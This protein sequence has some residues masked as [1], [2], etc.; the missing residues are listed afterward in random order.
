MIAPVARICDMHVCAMQTPA[1]VPI[2]HVGGTI[3]TPGVPTVLAGGIPIVALG[4]C[5][6]CVVGAIP[7]PFIVGSFTVLAMGRPIV[8][9]SDPLAHGGN[10]IIGFPTV[11]VGDSGGGGS[12]Q[13]ATMSAAKAGGSAFTRAECNPKAAEAVTRQV[14]PPP[15]ATGTTWVEV[16]V[17]DNDG[18]P[19]PYQKVR[20]TDSGGTARIAYSDPKGIARVDGMAKGDC[21]ITLADLDRSS[22]EAA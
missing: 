3:I 12:P 9:I 17:V 7:N 20:V 21:K 6:I 11:M 4:D 5:G 18:K 1:I 14:A 15:P 2:P 8:R 22:W 13:A 10:V 19:M 16:E